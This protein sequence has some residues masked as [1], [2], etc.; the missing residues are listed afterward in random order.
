MRKHLLMGSLFATV[1]LFFTPMV[2]AVEWKT[3]QT[4]LRTLNIQEPRLQDILTSDDQGP[5]PT[6]II[7]LTVLIL[8]L[9]FVRFT[10]QH[11]R[12]ILLGILVLILIKMFGG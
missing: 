8:L 2:S 9:K 3:V 6:C 7:W 12:Q 4:E 5:Q 11:I 1:L 10:M